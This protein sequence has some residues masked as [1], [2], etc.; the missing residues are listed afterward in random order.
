MFIRFVHWF[1]RID[2]SRCDNVL[3]KLMKLTNVQHITV[4]IWPSSLGSLVAVRALPFRFPRWSF[5]EVLSQSTHL[6]V[7]F[8]LIFPS[9]YVLVY[10]FYRWRCVCISYVAACRIFHHKLHF[11]YFYQLNVSKNVN[12][13]AF[14]YAKCKFFFIPPSSTGVLVASARGKWNITPN[15]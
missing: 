10:R 5:S 7:D 11:A 9:A 3:S 1:V 15:Q 13:C 14:K 4:F 8:L 12:L 2:D 6:S